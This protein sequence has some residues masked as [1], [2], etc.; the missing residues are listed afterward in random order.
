[1]MMPPTDPRSG[2][3]MSAGARAT[4]GAA[5]TGSVAEFSNAIERCK[6]MVQHLSN[7]L[8]NYLIQLTIF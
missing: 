3:G 8:S 6:A 4:Q 2:L 5:P 7:G 1:M